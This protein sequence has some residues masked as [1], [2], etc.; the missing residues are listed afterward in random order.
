VVKNLGVKKEY[1][2][3]FLTTPLIMMLNSSKIIELIFLNKLL[4]TISQHSGIEG[5]FFTGYDTAKLY[6]FLL[7]LILIGMIKHE[8]SKVKAKKR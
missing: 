4:Y 7:I 5:K 8:L 2:I 3:R 1:F 6:I